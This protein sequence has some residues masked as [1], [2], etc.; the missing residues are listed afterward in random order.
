VLD[1]ANITQIVNLPGV[2]INLVDQPGTGTSALV[3][4]EFMSNTSLID[5]RNIFAPVITLPNLEQLFGTA[6]K[7]R[8]QCL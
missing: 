3:Q 5:G 2:G 1:A 7:S 6:G 4:G 8:T